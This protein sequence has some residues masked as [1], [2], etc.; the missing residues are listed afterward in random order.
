MR[1]IGSVTLFRAILLG[2]VQV[3]GAIVAA[4]LVSVLFSEGLNDSTTLSTTATLAQEFFIEIILTTQL[5]FAISMLAAE[6]NA[7]TFIAS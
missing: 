4:A 7:G 1:I 6:K 2:I 3:L 5:V